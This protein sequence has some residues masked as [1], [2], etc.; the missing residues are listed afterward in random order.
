[1]QGFQRIHLAP[2]EKKT[3]HLSLDPGQISLVDDQGRRVIEP[4]Q[5][6]VSVG[7]GQPD[8]PNTAVLTKAF[9][10]IGEVTAVA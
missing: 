2:G 5:F 4:G 1:L 6:V 9:K 10:V 8:A 3:V 7:G